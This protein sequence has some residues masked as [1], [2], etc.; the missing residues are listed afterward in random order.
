MTEYWHQVRDRSSGIPTFQSMSP[1]LFPLPVLTLPSKPKSSSARVR[2]RYAIARYSSFLV[3][4]S[5]STLNRL[6][7]SSSF[8]ASSVNVESASSSQLRI[9]AH[10]YRVCKRFVCFSCD[11]S[12]T[13]SYS[14]TGSGSDKNTSCSSDQFD[15]STVPVHVI[16]CNYL[17][18][19]LSVSSPIPSVAQAAG[20]HHHYFH[21]SSSSSRS[22]PMDS[23]VFD[24]NSNPV[25][26]SASY[27]GVDPSVGAIPI[28]ADRVSLPSRLSSV[29][30]IS[31]LPPALA[32]VYEK[33]SA[34]LLSDGIPI[35]PNTD[36]IVAKFYGKTNEYIRLLQRMRDLNMIAF[37]T[38][39]KAVNGLFGVPKDGTDIRLIIDATPANRFFI[40]CPPVSLPDPG[41][42]ARLSVSKGDQLWMA[43]TDLESFYH[44]LLMPEWLQ[45]YFALPGFDAKEL[46]AAGLI[47]PD[48]YQTNTMVYPMCTTLPM[49]WSHS[50]FVGQSV[51]EN[52][53]YT[54]GKLN[55]KDNIICLS[56]P[57]IDRPLHGLIVDDIGIFSNR[58]YTCEV[59]LSQLMDAYVKV[60]LQVKW[61]K[62]RLPSTDPMQFLGMLVGGTD[63][64]IRLPIDKLRRLVCLTI[65]LLRS[66][67]V[68]GTQLQRVIGLWTWQLMLA[69]PA[70]S[71][72]HYS[73]R[74]MR[75]LDQQ[76]GIL[77]PSVRSELVSLL[78]LLPLLQISLSDTWH[79]RLIATDASQYAAGVVS[80]SLSHSL[81]NL[82]WPLTASR[83]TLHVQINGL[84]RYRRE[85]N[86]TRL[87]SY[88]TAMDTYYLVQPSVSLLRSDIE[89]ELVQMNRDSIRYTQLISS[90]TVHW[91][92][93]IS[94]KWKWEQHINTLE[95]QSIIIALKRLLSSPAVSQHRI[96]LLCDSTVVAYALTKGRSSAVSLARGM[97]KIAALLL[98]SGCRM[99]VAWI[100][101]QINPADK[102]SR[103]IVPARG[104]FG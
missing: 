35:G 104:G 92:T 40:P 69:R 82:L 67:R 9:L 96:M 50:V 10:L 31:L 20:T 58:K 41:S 30:L 103:A 81:F 55:P 77:W 11:S 47:S 2:Q 14:N 70:L 87:E 27:F 19:C 91:H 46:I 12:R 86:D 17:S 102:P 3:N 45:S 18:E 63:V 34:V 33:P 56:S 36:S 93:L 97:K 100:P 39:P 73:Y 78:S 85:P 89:S 28:I 59:S 38:T 101:T 80:T 13:A 16:L 21:S 53:A 51:H 43:K 22:L 29:P 54:H 66:A 6:Y 1:S 26:V 83:H 94:S 84:I 64:L 65:D 48:M 5:I 42:L 7:C 24:S 44:Q 71:V 72:L 52:V 76:Q 68:S 95:L 57:V 61:N 49:G 60:G 79:P 23:K 99:G 37:T 32:V 88:S 62:L 74:Y 90:P 4:H 25:S 8:P 75:I 15:V 98:S